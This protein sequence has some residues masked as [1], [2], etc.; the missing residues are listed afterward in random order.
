VHSLSPSGL[1]AKRVISGVGIGCVVPKVDYRVLVEEDF[2]QLCD[3]LA[4][5]RACIPHERKF[6][7]RELRGWI[8][9]DPDYHREGNI[10]ACIGPEIVGF[11]QVFVEKARL[12]AGK[13]DAVV[14]VDVVPECRNVGIEQEL[15]R[16]A[17]GHTRSRGVSKA[18]FR[19][20]EINQWKISLAES[21]AFTEDYRIFD[22]KRSGRSPL[23]IISAPSDMTL[24]RRMM[25]ECS[26]DYLRLVND[27]LNESFV[28]HHNSV[29]YPPE[30]LLTWRDFMEDIL[31]VM[32]AKVRGT[33]VGVCISEDSVKLNLEKGT[34]SGYIPVLGVIPAYRKMGAGRAMLADGMQWLLDRGRD[35]IY[36]SLVAENEKAMALYYSLGF[37]KSNEAVWY[38]RPVAENA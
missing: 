36:I 18:R 24:E 29:P 15:M 6:T 27:L 38:T 22:L 31:M 20:D 34:N 21:S 35:T 32:L 12:D 19:V 13:D 2:E 17:L 25:K 23:P 11:G 16:W 9:E 30:R 14:D 26:D 4:R 1:L 7:P 10:V 5:S 3:V 37:E 28:D 33:P 8:L